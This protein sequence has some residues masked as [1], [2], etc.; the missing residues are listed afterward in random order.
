MPPWNQMS[1]QQQQMLLSIMMNRGTA[2]MP[3]FGAGMAMPGGVPGAG[4]PGMMQPG[5]PMPGGQVQLQPSGLTSAMGNM[6][7]NPLTNQMNPAMGQMNPMLMHY[8]LSQQGGQ[9][10]QQPSLADL[11]SMRGG[12]MGL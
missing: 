11:L 5:T 10:M 3:Q 7:A 8:L 12:G 9:G 6:P 1:P 2:G 4:M